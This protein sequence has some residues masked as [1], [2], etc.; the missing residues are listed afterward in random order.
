MDFKKFCDSPTYTNF[1]KLDNNKKH[2]LILYSKYVIK[3]NVMNNNL[4]DHFNKYI[5]ELIEGYLYRKQKVQKKLSKIIKDIFYKIKYREDKSKEDILA[6][7]LR[8]LENQIKDILKIKTISENFLNWINEKDHWVDIL[9]DKNN[10]YK[11]ICINTIVNKSLFSD[12]L[13]INLAIKLNIYKKGDLFMEKYKILK[14]SI[15]MI[16]MYDIYKT[17][18]DHDHYPYLRILTNKSEMIIKTYV[19]DPNFDFIFEKINAKLSLKDIYEQLLFL[20]SNQDIKIKNIDIILD[21]NKVNPIYRNKKLIFR[22]DNIIEEQTDIDVKN[23]VDKISK[24]NENK[25]CSVCLLLNH[26][27][28]K[29]CIACDTPF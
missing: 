12:N 10:I 2:L 4:R 8:E 23:I 14:R 13:N 27:E 21:K 17:K 22:S 6:E 19:N 15:K 28:N 5:E 3:I 29:K 25:Q 20:F 16:F 18:N 11:N 7:I 1:K 9:H 24:F 26:I